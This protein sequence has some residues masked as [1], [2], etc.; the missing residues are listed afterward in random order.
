VPTRYV[1]GF[2]PGEESRNAGHYVVRESDAHAWIEALVPGR[3]W[4]ELDP[5]PATQLASFRAGHEDGWFGRAWDWLTAAFAAL[6]AHLSFGGWAPIWALLR[7]PAVLVGIALVLAVAGAFRLRLLRP[8][9]VRV[10]AP[11]T[12]ESQVPPEIA[13]LLASL[14]AACA[15]RGY[16]R[17]PH[18]APLEHV[19]SL[20]TLPAAAQAASERAVDCFYAARFGRHSL[21]A[22]EVAQIRAD[23]ERTLGVR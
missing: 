23:M 8:R 11:I 17:P 12:D 15:R 18:R 2:S 5:T 20:T 10:A 4:V 9:R 7:S 3:G 6:R 16:P 14:D 22:A 19:R 21:P 1:S 13:A